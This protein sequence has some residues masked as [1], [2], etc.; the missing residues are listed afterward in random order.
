MVSI[1]LLPVALVSPVLARDFLPAH[2]TAR[3]VL[4]RSRLLRRVLQHIARRPTRT[5][6][7]KLT[8]RAH[9]SRS[10]A[11]FHPV[12]FGR[13]TFAMIPATRVFQR[14]QK[15]DARSDSGFRSAPLGPA[16]VHPI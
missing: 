8:K 12:L 13:V 16:V 15:R 3:I 7:A 9:A 1:L 14:A 2:E 6:D 5:R 10:A 11:Y 4:G